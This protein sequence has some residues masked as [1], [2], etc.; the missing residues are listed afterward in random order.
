MKIWVISARAFYDYTEYF[1]RLE[2][3]EVA[4]TEEEAKELFNKMCSSERDWFWDGVDAHG[5][6]DHVYIDD[7]TYQLTSDEAVCVVS[8]RAVE[9]P[10]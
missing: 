6:Y 8:L 1:P 5:D 4:R 10:D 2:E 7:N 3:T 9:L